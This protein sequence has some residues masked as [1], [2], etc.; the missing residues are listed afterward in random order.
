MLYN[1]LIIKNRIF[2]I[3]MMYVTRRQNI[4]NIIFYNI[5]EMIL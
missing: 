1:F 3:Y 5:F 4:K 2:L